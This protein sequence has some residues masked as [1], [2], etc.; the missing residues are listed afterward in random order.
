MTKA[1]V[2][3]VANATDSAQNPVLKIAELEAADEEASTPNAI[4][5]SVRGLVQHGPPHKRNE[6]GALQQPEA[7][8]EVLTPNAIAESARR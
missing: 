5:E 2:G 4:A 8:E 7:E 6:L 3:P 1:E